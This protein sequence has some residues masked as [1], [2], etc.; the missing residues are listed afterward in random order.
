MAI[1]QPTLPSEMPNPSVIN[2]TLRL[3]HKNV[4]RVLYPS[5]ND[6][7]LAESLRASD[8]VQM[9]EKIWYSKQ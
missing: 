8:F 3:I 2:E 5:E 9:E 1:L 4:D 6:I 7:S